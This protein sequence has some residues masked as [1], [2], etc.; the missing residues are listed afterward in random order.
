MGTEPLETYQ[1]EAKSAPRFSFSIVK[2]AASVVSPAVLSWWSSERKR[3]REVSVGAS[4][5]GRHW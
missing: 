4:L 5:R 1:Q 2:W 3:K